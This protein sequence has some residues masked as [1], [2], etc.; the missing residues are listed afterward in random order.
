MSR[1]AGAQA[2]HTA[3]SCTGQGLP[4]EV[5]REYGRILGWAE[6]ALG[7]LDAQCT[8]APLP[9]RAHPVRVNR[10]SIAAMPPPRG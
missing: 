2:L 8:N 7:Y 3:H 5:E 4:I 9:E 10:M 1:A 6:K